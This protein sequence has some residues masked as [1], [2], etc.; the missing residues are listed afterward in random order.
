MSKKKTVEEEPVVDK[1]ET[2][3]DLALQAINKQFGKGSIQRF[4]GGVIPGIEFIPTGSVSLDRALGGGFARGRIIEIYGPESSGKT[5]LTLSAISECQKAGGTCAFIDA[6]HALDIKY[7]GQIGVVVE[8]LLVSQ[9][10]SGE[11]ALQIADMLARS[12]AVDLIVIDSVAALVPQAEL[13]GDMGDHHIGTQSRLMSQAMRK[14]SGLMHTSDTSIIFINQI[15]MK[16][17]VMFGNPETT[18]GGNALK[19][20]AS[21]RLDIRSPQSAKIKLGGDGSEIIG[22]KTK[23]KV[24]KNKVAPPFKEAYF[25]LIFGQGIDKMA[26]LITLAAEL[27]VVNKS[28]SW[29]SYQDERIGQG[30]S[31]AA[32]YLSDTP[33]VAEEIR[34]IVMS[35]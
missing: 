21:Q 7:A 22:K 10:S 3:L 32:N 1:K 28:G 14:L 25:N 23:V 2:A 34:E 24:V 18:S 15:R 31:Q 35:L 12:G 30:V 19:F 13:E 16:I 26:D 29:Y 8:D 17:G 5:T 4:N 6:E 11:E 33:Q 9:P 20:Y 27:G